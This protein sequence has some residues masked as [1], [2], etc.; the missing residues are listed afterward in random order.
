MKFRPLHGWKDGMVWVRVRFTGLDISEKCISVLLLPH[1]EK[2]QTEGID[3]TGAN[4]ESLTKQNRALQ[5][6][7]KGEV[8]HERMFHRNTEID[9][10]DVKRYLEDTE[11]PKTL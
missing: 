6:V 7:M 2:L 4:H 8:P 5:M 3:Y 11:P 10:D 9:L 1:A